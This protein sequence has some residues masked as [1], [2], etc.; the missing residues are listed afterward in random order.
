MTN[1]SAGVVILIHLAA[2]LGVL[3]LLVLTLAV[4]V[5]SAEFK[6]DF[7]IATNGNDAWSG[8]LP[9]PGPGGADGP[10]ATLARAQQALR[11][12]KPTGPVTVAVRGGTY[13]LKEPLVFSPEDSGTMAAPIT[14]TA[15]PGE[16]P[17]FSGGRRISDWRVVDGHWDAV[18]PGVK[19]G[20]WNFAQLFVNNERRYRTR[21]P[22]VGYYT[23]ADQAPPSPAAGT[24]G[25]DSFQF[26]ESDI[27][28]DW[29]NPDDVE[30]LPFHIWGMGRHYIASVDETR[31]IVTFTGTTAGTSW[32]A[33]LP[34]GNRYLVENVREALDT[35]G[36]WYLD[37]KD[38]VLTY[39]P[40]AGEDPA[41]TE[42]FA[43]FL[44][45][46]LLMKGEVADRRWIEYVT[47]R[48]L[49][50][51]HSN[52]NTPQRGHDVP[53]SESDL[54]A[55]VSF[56]GVRNCVLEDCRIL[57]V[58]AYGLELGKGCR[59]DRIENSELSDLG[60]GGI[61]LGSMDIPGDDEAAAGNC[62]IS[63][64]VIAHGGRLHPAGVGV[65]IGESPGNEVTHNEITDFYQ[66]GVSE[67]WTWGYGKS[68][69]AN[70]HISYNHIHNIG[71]GV[72]SDMGGIYTLGSRPTTM[73]DHNLIHDIDS[74]SYGGWGIYFDEGSTGVLA[75][76]NIV[77]RTK[78]AGF[79]Q[80]YGK[81]NMLRNNIFALGREAQLMRTR[82]EDH[83]SFTVEHC[84]M[85]AKDAPI[86][87]GNWSGNNYHLDDNLYWNPDGKP[88]RMAGKDWAQWQAGGQ[89][90]HSLVADPQ[91]VDPEKG[92]FHFKSDSPA[93]KIGF[94][95]IDTTGIGPAA[96]T[97]PVASVPAAFPTL[98]AKL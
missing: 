24:R 4:P 37:R 79:H 30:V 60:A 7:F 46:L 13:F 66:I 69:A 41:R 29:H 2:R 89:D 23:I 97:P 95:P 19:T 70:N 67:G 62:T 76:N 82:A 27:R 3:A 91:F 28:T 11:E 58:G 10:F 64:C 65:W 85:F 36:Q 53:Q 17:V 80:H 32:W 40:R 72:L 6:A 16:Q 44:S 54:S 22:K 1:E 8:K 83:L 39:L 50:F 88:V 75:T 48:G 25:E 5:R 38:G 78:S 61:K 47:F 92:D 93:A 52:W 90:A 31:R 55:A 59:S 9:D 26:A 56:V 74:F 21:L 15:F 33:S 63:G 86:L 68:L 96:G 84:I 57:H 71:Q 77:Y 20:D 43:P 98:G 12:R 94:E 35:P 49:T 34:K 14:Y 45:Q 73:L 81:D 42:V 18:V 51:A 87:G